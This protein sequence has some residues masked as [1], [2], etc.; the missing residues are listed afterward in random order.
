MNERLATGEVE[1]STH[2]QSVGEWSLMRQVA[3][4]RT[5]ETPS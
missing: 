1:L 5:S 3:A 4:R 2:A